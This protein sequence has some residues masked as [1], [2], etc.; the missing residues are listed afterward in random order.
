MTPPFG[1]QPYGAPVPTPYNYPGAPRKKSGS[2]CCGCFVGCLA[3]ILLPP[4]IFT[5]LYFTVD[6][7]EKTDQFLIRGYYS[8]ARSA[9]EAGFD[10]KFSEAEKKQTMEVLDF[11]V[12]AYAKLPKEERALVRK[13]AVIYLYYSRQNEEPPR[14]KVPHFLNFIDSNLDKLKEKHMPPPTNP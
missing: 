1:Q 5:I 13:E 9:I 12:D 3:L 7:G 8:Y 2:G 11:F 14:E 4:L 6:L 10:A